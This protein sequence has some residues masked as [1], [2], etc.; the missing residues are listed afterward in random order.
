M[1]NFYDVKPGEKQPVR[2]FDNE[3]YNPTIIYPYT[4]DGEENL[5]KFVMISLSS[6]FLTVF[7]NSIARTR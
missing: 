3:E 6:N 1:G 7:N 4:H 5:N 2:G